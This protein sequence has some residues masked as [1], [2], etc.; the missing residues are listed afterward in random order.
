MKH[1]HIE[2]NDQDCAWKNDIYAFYSEGKLRRMKNVDG[3]LKKAANSST[4]IGMEAF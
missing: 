1:M 4:F 3:V 2:M